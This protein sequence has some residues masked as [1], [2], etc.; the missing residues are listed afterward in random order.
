MI[1][2]G[3][4]TNGVLDYGATRPVRL[5][6]GD[7]TGDLPQAAE[8]LLNVVGMGDGR[9]GPVMGFDGE[10]SRSLDL[11]EFRDGFVLARMRLL[12]TIGVGE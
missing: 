10:D 12:Q 3:E 4:N 7:R 6:A 5:P 2:I 8:Q 1:L 9:V 11:Y